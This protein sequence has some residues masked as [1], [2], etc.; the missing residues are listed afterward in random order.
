MP[1]LTFV[2]RLRQRFPLLEPAG[3]FVLAGSAVGYVALKDP[4]EAGHFPTCPFLFITGYYCPGCGSLRTIHALTHFDIETAL[5]ANIFAVAMFPVLIFYF[6]R[7]TAVRF[8]GGPV[9]RKVMH[10]MWIWALFGLVL[11][12]WLLRNL[13][14]LAFL[15]PYGVPP[16]DLNWR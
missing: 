12:F 7:W 13:E 3:V 6:V 14:P 5:T 9:R 15:A 2:T 8:T 10:P 11:S 16:G 4:N 1:E